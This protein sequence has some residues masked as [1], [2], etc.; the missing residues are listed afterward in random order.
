MVAISLLL[1]GVLVGIVIGYSVVPRKSRSRSSVRNRA[2]SQGEGGF[3]DSI[4]QAMAVA[5]GI[6]YAEFSNKIF[7]HVVTE[8]D[9]IYVLTKVNKYLRE[10]RDLV[11]ETYLGSQMLSSGEQS[12]SEMVV[13]KAESLFL[14]I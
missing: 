5:F 6:F 7:R 4:E 12:V 9:R 3:R 13:A 8:E 10:K 1:V 11:A 14:Q 2:I